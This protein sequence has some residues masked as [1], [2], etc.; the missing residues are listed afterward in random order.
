MIRHETTCSRTGIVTE[1]WSPTPDEIRE[2]IRS[3]LGHVADGWDLAEQQ[4][5]PGRLE[6]WYQL[7]GRDNPEHPLHGV[8]SGLC[9]KYGGPAPF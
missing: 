6:R 3:S 1:W 9:A 2:A 4:A 5:R 7:D 8:F